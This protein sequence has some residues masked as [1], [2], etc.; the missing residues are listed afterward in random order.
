MLAVRPKMSVAWRVRGGIA[1]GSMF[2]IAVFL[3]Q[4]GTGNYSLFTLHPLLMMVAFLLCMGEGIVHYKVSE[5]DLSIA[6]KQHRNIFILAGML[7]MVSVFVILLN[8]YNVGHSMTPHTAHAICGVLTIFMFLFQGTVGLRK[9]KALLQSNGH[10]KMHR[11]HGAFGIVT[12]GMA[13]ITMILGFRE[14][15]GSNSYSMALA[16]LSIVAVFAIVVHTHLKRER[17]VVDDTAYGVVK[18]D[19]IDDIQFETEPTDYA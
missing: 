2:A 3:F 6:R 10:N 7:S 1:V 16:G 15:V 8:K 17:T 18:A 5:E 4:D 19:E 9:L 11:W 12:L 13:A 14:I